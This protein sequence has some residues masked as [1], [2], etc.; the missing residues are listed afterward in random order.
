MRATYIVLIMAQYLILSSFQ[1]ISWIISYPVDQI[2]N[3]SK[4]LILWK[5]LATSV[6]TTLELDLAGKVC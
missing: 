4:A 3:L 6:K 2:M 1:V 5:D